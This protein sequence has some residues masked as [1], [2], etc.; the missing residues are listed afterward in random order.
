[1]SIFKTYT[2]AERLKAQFRAEALNAFN[3]PMFRSP[4]TR[5][6]NANFGRVTSQANFPRMLQLGVRIFF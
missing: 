6:G 4:E 1:M 5:V 2:I 3:T